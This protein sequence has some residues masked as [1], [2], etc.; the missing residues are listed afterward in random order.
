MGKI[1]FVEE[2]QRYYEA[3]D[4]VWA[5]RDAAQVEG[6]G[7][8]Y[9][10]A[11]WPHVAENN[12]TPRYCD[13]GRDVNPPPPQTYDEAVAYLLNQLKEADRQPLRALS[14]EQLRDFH[15]SWGMGIRNGLDLWREDNP[16]IRSYAERKGFADDEFWVR[17]APE[18]ISSDLIESVWESLQST[19]DE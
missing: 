8:I 14:R 13:D 12:S 10:Y 15:F 9:R 4:E 7:R 19:A 17:M 5:A 11:D 1:I 18:F 6:R 3:E 2:E 16:V